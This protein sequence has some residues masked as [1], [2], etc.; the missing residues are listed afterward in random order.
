MNSLWSSLPGDV[1]STW[2]KQFFKVAERQMLSLMNGLFI[3]LCHIVPFFSQ[4]IPF[5]IWILSEKCKWK[6]PFYLKYIE[7]MCGS[8]L[9]S[10]FSP[11]IPSP[12]TQKWWT[13]VIRWTPIVNIL[14][15][16]GQDTHLMMATHH[17]LPAIWQGRENSVIFILKMVELHH[18]VYNSFNQSINE[19]FT[20]RGFCIKHLGDNQI[21]KKRKF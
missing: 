7:N 6:V 8:W 16:D 19:S 17:K 18:K 3:K 9:A 2:V 11:P 15:Y 20:F 12:P 1:R 10:Q 5:D 4:K 21:I 13:C 14:P